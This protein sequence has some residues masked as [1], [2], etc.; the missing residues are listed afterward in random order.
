MNLRRKFKKA[1]NLWQKK[2]WIG[3][4]PS[5]HFKVISLKE[6]FAYQRWI[7]K[8]D[9]LTDKDR[10]EI[11][12]QIQKFSYEP[13]I[14]II[15][16]V[17]NVEEK[18]LRLCIESV[19]KQI[20]ENWELCIA[21]DCSP[22]PHIRNILE[23]YEKK[24]EQIKVVFRP[25]NGHISAASNSALEIATGEFC[26][27]LDH[28]D[29][30]A[31]HALFYV[32]KEIND[33][34]ETEMIYSDED[35]ISEKGR[36]FSPKFK[37]DWSRDYFYSGNLITHLSC[38]KTD[39][40][41]NIGGF[42]IGFEGSQD[43]DLALRFIEEICEDHI[44]HVPKIL[45]HWRVIEGSV[46]HSS[47][48]KPYAHETAR[49]AIGEHLTRLGKKAK[50]VE[51]VHNLH[52]V[53][54]ELP[55]VL[56]KVSLI[57]LTDGDF[58]FKKKAIEDFAKET[59][60]PN[61]EIAVVCSKKL[62]QKFEVENTKAE[63]RLLRSVLSHQDSSEAEK[64]NQSV[65]ETDG[66]ILCFVDLNL[67]PVHK[68]WLKELVS[69]AFQKEIGAVGGKLLSKVETV[70]GSGLLIGVG[71]A[72]GIAHQG[73]PCEKDG[74]LTRNRLVNN[75]SAVSVS[76]LAT[77]RETFENVGGFDAENFP[78][79]FFDVDF[80]L[81]LREENLRIVFTPYA[82]LMQIDESKLLNIQKHASESERE[83]FR[84]KWQ[85]YIERDPFYNPN[86]SKENGHFLIDL[87]N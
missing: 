5:L 60:Y 25:E 35:L 81:K 87:S 12:Q 83:N 50:V 28:D 11:R 86:L 55:E 15:L 36:R 46:S 38:Y 34:P 30:L 84:K 26:V 44:R 29:K 17:Y 43:Y 72:V 62:K 42:R 49:R 32:A 76:C 24:D 66:E 40:L 58:D 9:T 51:T 75:F 45:Y 79:K 19:R 54:Y 21:D 3:L 14:S 74:S 27:L 4:K 68:N 22:S 85:K 20:Y 56:P 16:P 77:H 53:R 80:C 48:A 10:E 8:F 82:E 67:R 65:A 71:G 7:R 1:I 2:G 73:L 52:R 61:L 31:E 78:N 13:L 39:I 18:F 33:F 41:R 63:T 59:D 57:F 47:D 64:Y 69:F 70:L 6:K 37:P 23:E